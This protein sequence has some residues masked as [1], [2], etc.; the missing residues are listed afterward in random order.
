MARTCTSREPTTRDGTTTPSIPRSPSSPRAI[1]R[2][3]SWDG[4]RQPEIRTAPSATST[5]AVAMWLTNGGTTV[6][7]S[8]LGAVAMSWAIVGVGDFDGD[9][10]ADILWRDAAGNLALWLMNG[11]AVV[12][13]V[14]VGNIGSA[15]SPLVGDFDGDGKADIL[16]RHTASGAVVMWLMNGGRLT[17]TIDL[18]TVPTTWTI[19]GVGDFDGDRRAEDRKSTRLNSS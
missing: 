10:H 7:V 4:H 19:L 17:S 8:D 14:G 13:T 15:W 18:G 11:G 3:S 9:G 5:G 6:S 2:W 1:S 12:S 16:W